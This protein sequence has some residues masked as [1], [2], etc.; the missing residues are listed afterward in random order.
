MA[1]L[2][3]WGVRQD[4][5]LVGVRVAIDN[6]T[7]KRLTSVGSTP[8]R[9]SAH[10]LDEKGAIIEHDA[11][12]NWLHGGIP[13]RGR[14]SAA[15]LFHIV[16]RRAHSLRLCLVQENVAWIEHGGIDVDIG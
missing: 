8:L 12:R 1:F 6:G 11:E 10:V 16:D 13:A 3:P 2:R 5:R 9:L 7:H 14:A 4:A 15:G